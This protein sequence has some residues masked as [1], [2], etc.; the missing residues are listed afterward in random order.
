MV[1]FVIPAC[2]IVIRPA[3]YDGYLTGA[4]RPSQ[5]ERKVL[6]YRQSWEAALFDGYLMDRPLQEALMRNNGN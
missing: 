1:L 5:D 3:M 6:S 4:G 2:Q